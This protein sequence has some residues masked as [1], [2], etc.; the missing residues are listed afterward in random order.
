VDGGYAP[1]DLSHKTAA[2]PRHFP[3]EL[4]ASLRARFG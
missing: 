4:K 2:I 1:V 3:A